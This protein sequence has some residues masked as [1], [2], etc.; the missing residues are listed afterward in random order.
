MKKVKKNNGEVGEV[1]GNIKA[2]KKTRECASQY[3][4]CVWNNYDGEYG[5]DG[6]YITD[7]LR[8]VLNQ[9]EFEWELDDKGCRYL[10]RPQEGV[11]DGTHHLQGCIRFPKRVRPYPGEF[12]DRL[13]L[14]WEKARDWKSLKTYCA[15]DETST[16]PI[17]TNMPGIPKLD[18][19]MEGLSRKPWQKMIMEIIDK[20]PDKRKIYWFY[21]SEGQSGKT[22]FA[23]YLVI[24]NQAI[25]VDGKANDI[26]HM[27]ADR[28]KINS[29]PRI[30]IFDFVRSKECYVSYEAIEAVKNGIFFSGK[31]ESS[32]VVFNNPHVI[33]FANFRPD[34]SKLSADRWDIH[35]I[36]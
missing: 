25:Y 36:G 21:D 9:I 26:K 14:C 34:E 6:E 15:R 5:E 20:P 22:T 8:G 30:V 31:Y 24:Y 4:S 10:W 11:E 23:K 33:C 12:P 19:P 16:G 13:Y 7:P 18:D 32:Q 28:L 35:C 3:W 17:H 27:I 1:P 29:M 2:P